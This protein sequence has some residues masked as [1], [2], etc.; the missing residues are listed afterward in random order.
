M[1]F[2]PDELPFVAGVPDVPGAVAVGGFTG[3]GMGL[4]L[5]VGQIV[6]RRLLGRADAAD[7]LLAPPGER[8]NSRPASHA[9]PVIR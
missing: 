4:G 7:D 9:R 5:R 8:A 3:H 2:S 1:G 6:A